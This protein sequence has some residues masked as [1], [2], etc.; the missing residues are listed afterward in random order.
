[1]YG[2]WYP[3]STFANDS[4]FFFQNDSCSLTK[5]KKTVLWY[6]S[7]SRKSINFI[8]S[9]GVQAKLQGW[10]A[11]LLYQAS[12]TTL[13]SS[14]LQ[15]MPLYTFFCFRVLETVCNKL[16]LPPEPSGGTMSL[17]LGNYIWPSGIQYVNQKKWVDLDSKK[18]I[19]INQ[20]MISKQYWRIQSS[21]PSL[22]AKTFE[23]KYFPRSSLQDYKP[24]SHHSWIWKNVTT[25]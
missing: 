11:K 14:I 7:I 21:P 2:W 1:M 4:L 25:P 12:G 19:L 3:S 22:L 13:I 20:A 23:A 17:E 15:V 6:C 18:F 10:Q 24:K 16:D 9:D 5:K 8:K